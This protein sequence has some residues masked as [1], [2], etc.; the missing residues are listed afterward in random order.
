MDDRL[1]SEYSLKLSLIINLEISFDFSLFITRGEIISFILQCMGAPLVT[2]SVTAS[3]R[4]KRAILNL[5]KENVWLASLLKK[6]SYNEY[7]L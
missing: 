2:S 1:H 3:T 7:H 4:L 5:W 6:L